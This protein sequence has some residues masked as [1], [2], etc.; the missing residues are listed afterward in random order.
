[1]T[2]PSR[3]LTLR[4]S[5]VDCTSST[6][7]SA[8]DAEKL[9]PRLLEFCT[10]LCHK[11]L[12]RAEFVRAKPKIIRQLYR[13]QPEL[14]RRLVAIDMDVRRFVWLVTVKIK[15]IRAGPE[16]SRHAEILANSHGISV[17]A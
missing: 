1:M 3:R 2:R 12:Y 13:F 17:S 8:A 6:R 4:A 14:S 15:T 9:I 11:R 5:S 7:S 10:V 16:H